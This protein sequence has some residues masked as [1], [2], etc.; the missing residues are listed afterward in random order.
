MKLIIL[1]K[2]ENMNIIEI[3]FPELFKELTFTNLP[4]PLEKKGLSIST[5]LPFNQVIQFGN[6]GINAI[7]FKILH[8]Q[9]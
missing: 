8:V 6:I 3:V 4:C 9:R 7:N 5:I 2:I 1:F